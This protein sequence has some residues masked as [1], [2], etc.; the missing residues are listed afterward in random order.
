MANINVQVE[1]NTSG[2]GHAAECYDELRSA[3]LGLQGVMELL[4]D[5]NSVSGEGVWHLLALI[6]N[7]MSGTLDK[8]HRAL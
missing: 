6:D 7:Q 3:Q 2:F 8:L 4:S 1:V 5:K